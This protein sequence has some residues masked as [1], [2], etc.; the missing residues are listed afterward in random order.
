MR[1]PD[2]K[3]VLLGMLIP[4]LAWALLMFGV[5]VGNMVVN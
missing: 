1:D 3:A 4:I 5:V 2:G